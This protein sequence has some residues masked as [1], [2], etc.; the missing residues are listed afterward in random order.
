MPKKTRGKVRV[1]RQA[2]PVRISASYKA[3]LVALQRAQNKRMAT[4]LASKTAVLEAFAGITLRLDAEAWDTELERMIAEMQLSESVT[5]SV[6]ARAKADGEKVL[7]HVSNQLI[8]V[9]ESRAVPVV[10][11]AQAVPSNASI[12]NSWAVENVRLIKRVNDDQR[13]RIA[14]I[15]SN[16]FRKGGRISA[17]KEELKATFGMGTKRADLI[18]Q[19]EIGNLYANLE[20]AEQQR[21]GVDYYQWDTRMDERVRP[22]HKAMQGKFCRWDDPTVYKDSLEDAKWKNRGDI[23]GVIA[24]PSEAIRC[25]CHAGAVLQ[26][27]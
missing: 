1:V 6:L 22:S 4:L 15:I 17:A 13:A 12:I 24:H 26:L 9:T 7:R 20:K 16:T 23:G 5:A 27:D 19:N 3:F 8:Q 14:S 10:L 21:L 18:A 2:Y 11:G 25:R